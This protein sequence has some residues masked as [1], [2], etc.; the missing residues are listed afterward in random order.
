MKKMTICFV[1]V[2]NYHFLGKKALTTF[3]V[4]TRKNWLYFF[5][6][7]VFF[8]MA[9]QMAQLQNKPMEIPEA[10][11]AVVTKERPN[12]WT[13]NITKDGDI[14]P[15]ASSDAV[16]VEQLTKLVSDEIRKI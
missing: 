2:Q 13:V 12:R 7:L 9:S 11:K 5:L 10:T 4:C 14:F 3:F 15:G 1:L 8:M 16:D 6:L